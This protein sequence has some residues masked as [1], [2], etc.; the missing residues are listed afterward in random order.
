[1]TT[2]VTKL[3]FIK[4]V[5]IHL[6]ACIFRKETMSFICGVPRARAYSGCVYL[7]CAIPLIYQ[8]MIVASR[9]K[10]GWIGGRENREE[11]EYLHA[12]LRD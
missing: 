2:K 3:F 9:Y 7:P 12:S 10:W 4:N 1:M 6:R 11:K 8:V 5:A